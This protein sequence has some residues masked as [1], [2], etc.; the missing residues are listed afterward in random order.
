[1]VSSY[2]RQLPAEER[3]A[4]KDARAL[5][6]RHCMAAKAKLEGRFDLEAD[7]SELVWEMA[8]ADGPLQA[9]AV[10]KQHNLQKEIFKEHDYL[11]MSFLLMCFSPAGIKI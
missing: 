5:L 6:K 3:S 8:I 11:R 2:E 10:T 1:M 9:D 7:D 4:L